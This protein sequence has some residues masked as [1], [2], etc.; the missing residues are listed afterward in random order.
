MKSFVLA[1]DIVSFGDGNYV[2]PT[3]TNVDTI[4]RL[5]CTRSAAAHLEIVPD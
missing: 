1:V 5:P 4:L 2:A 3:P